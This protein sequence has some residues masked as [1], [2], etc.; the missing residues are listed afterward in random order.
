[1]SFRN[2]IIAT[3]LLIIILNKSLDDFDEILIGEKS[4]KKKLVIDRI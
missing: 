1:M 4:N 2:V 3:I